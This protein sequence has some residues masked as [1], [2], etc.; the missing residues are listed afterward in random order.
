MA[1]LI[2]NWPIIVIIDN[3]KIKLILT[4]II[5]KEGIKH[6][7]WINYGLNI[8]YF[9]ISINKN[10]LTLYKCKSIAK[11]KAYTPFFNE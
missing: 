11:M 1:E 3:Q 7:S 9:D 10:S 5:E 2:L 8:I 4:G 6:Y